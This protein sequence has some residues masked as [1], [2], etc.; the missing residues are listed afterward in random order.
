MPQSKEKLPNIIVILM[1]AAGAKRCSVYGHQRDTTP[2]LSR[3]AAEGTLYKHCFAPAPWTIPSH[4]S[5]FSGLYASEHGCDEKS[6]QL[7]EMVYS[8][9]EI[10]Q[11]RGYHTVAISSN[12]LVT[13]RRGF[14][15]FYE[16][17]TI[18][19]SED[20]HI[21]RIEMM[22]A[23]KSINSE[24]GRFKYLLQYIWEKKCFHFLII[25]IL[26]RLYRNNF[27][28]IFNNSSKA[29]KKSFDICKYLLK[30]HR[31]KNPL[32]I[33][34]NV[35]ET[36]W[37]YNPPP[38]YHKFSQLDQKARQEI[39]Q[40]DPF[41][42][43]VHG[44][45]PETLSALPL[46]YEEALAYVDEKIWDFYNAIKDI[47][48]LDE[49]LFIVTSDHGEILGEHGIWGHNLSLYNEM[50]HIPLIM[51]YPPQVVQPGEHSGV[52]Q[53]NDLYATILEIADI[54]LPPPESSVSLLSGRRD[55][56][57]AEH[58]NPWI[59]VDGCRRRDPDFKP[60]W[61]MQPCRCIIDSELH[62]LVEWLD[63]RL[64]FFDLKQDLGEEYN[65]VDRP[66]SQVRLGRLKQKLGEISDETFGNLTK[67]LGEFTG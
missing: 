37:K 66:E 40:T 57:I 61:F 49:T 14:D 6:L 65:L 10:L 39:L 19:Y 59:T 53:L 50:I 12:S 2:G 43:F 48:L 22:F 58:F 56:A 9:P 25:N 60:K 46:L 16:M 52:V 28:N 54:P 51:K 18:S 21:N 63:G 5:L 7:P 30:K 33:F 64:E 31:N 15:V 27:V 13:F 44:I 38:E 55:Y 8:L 3:I 20:Y 32:F 41:A 24:F 67:R 29:T 35:M 45:S 1:D 23:K 17:D 42:F 36:H 47:G 11:Q 4:A 62:K 26:D 34:V